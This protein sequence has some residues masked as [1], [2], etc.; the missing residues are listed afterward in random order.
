MVASSST[1]APVF[2]QRQPLVTPLSAMTTAA[3]ELR[4]ALVLAS[5]LSSAFVLAVLALAVLLPLTLAGLAAMSVSLMSS[6]PLS[7]S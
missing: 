1:S 2:L 4:A 3:L 6:F 5:V 7:V